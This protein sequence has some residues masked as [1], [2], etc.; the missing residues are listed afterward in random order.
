M[1]APLHELGAAAA[2]PLI[3]GPLDMEA[4]LVINRPWRLVQRGSTPGPAERA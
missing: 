2:D 1:H 3:K 4:G